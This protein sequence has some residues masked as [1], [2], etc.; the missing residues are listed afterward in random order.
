MYDC[1]HELGGNGMVTKMR[2]EI[3]NLHLKKGEEKHGQN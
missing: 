3:D 1:Y 2:T